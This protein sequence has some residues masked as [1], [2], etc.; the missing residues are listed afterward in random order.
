M[1]FVVDIKIIN[2]LKQLELPPCCVVT[3][4]TFGPNLSKSRIGDLNEHTLTAASKEKKVV[5]NILLFLIS[6]TVT[7]NHTDPRDFIVCV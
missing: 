5:F 6:R 1:L 7:N 3:L 2:V 4:V